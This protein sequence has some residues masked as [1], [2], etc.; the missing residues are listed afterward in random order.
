M[1]FPE[2][3]LF[4]E[5]LA[6]HLKYY[7]GY[8]FLDLINMCTYCWLQHLPLILKAIFL[9]WIPVYGALDKILIDNGGALAN[10]KFTS[11]IKYKSL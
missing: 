4:Q 1:S 10:I 3:S 5:T 9:I 7:Q 11:T 2:A 8:K 6:I